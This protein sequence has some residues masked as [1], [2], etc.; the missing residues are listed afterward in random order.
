MEGVTCQI[1]IMNEFD[2]GEV[3]CIIVPMVE[4]KYHWFEKRLF[5]SIELRDSF[6]FFT[7]KSKEK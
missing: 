3:P 1:F 2:F 5:F 4:K 7:F 6:L